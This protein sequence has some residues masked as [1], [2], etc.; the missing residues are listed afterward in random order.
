MIKHEDN[1]TSREKHP[2]LSTT[3]TS[4]SDQAQTLRTREVNQS[5]LDVKPLSTQITNRIKADNKWWEDHYCE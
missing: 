4:V 5:G 1:L 3:L 2:V